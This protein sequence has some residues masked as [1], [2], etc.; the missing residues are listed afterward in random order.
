MARLNEELLLLAR[1]VTIGAPL[2]RTNVGWRTRPVTLAV[3]ADAGRKRQRVGVERHHLVARGI[4]LDYC[5]RS[6]RQEEREG[7]KEEG[8]KL[9]D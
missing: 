9:H 3:G 5:T 2:G 6:A 4:T 1:T 7:D 8:E